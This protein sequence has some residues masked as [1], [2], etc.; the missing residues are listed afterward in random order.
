LQ[1]TVIAGIL[2]FWPYLPGDGCTTYPRHVHKWWF[3]FFKNLASKVSKNDEK[4]NK[5]VFHS[6]EV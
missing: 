4:L 2:T 3:H 1:G 6:G 5:K